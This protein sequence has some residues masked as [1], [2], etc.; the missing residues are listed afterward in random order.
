MATALSHRG[1]GR[2]VDPAARR[3][4]QA[5]IDGMAAYGRGMTPEQNPA[6]LEQL[7]LDSE[8]TVIDLTL[9]ERVLE[10]LQRV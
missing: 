2:S 6:T 3:R 5:V 10:D 9:L 8:R 7:L 4:S 1:V